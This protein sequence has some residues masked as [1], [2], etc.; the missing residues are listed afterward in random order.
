MAAE[1]LGPLLLQQAEEA[2]KAKEYDRAVDL[3]TQVS[4]WLIVRRLRQL[5]SFW[6]LLC[7][8]GLSSK[9]TRSI[10]MRTS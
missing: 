7:S 9:C 2:A 4:F 1:A 10:R 5:V 8:T 6:T 3:Y